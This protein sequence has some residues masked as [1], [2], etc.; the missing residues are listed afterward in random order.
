MIG[1]QLAQVK[2]GGLWEPLDHPQLAAF[3]EAL[4]PVNAVSQA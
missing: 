2:G 1:W 4:D 3:V